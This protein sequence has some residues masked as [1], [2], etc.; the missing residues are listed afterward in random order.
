MPGHHQGF[1]LAR[2][3]PPRGALEAHGVAGHRAHRS[4]LL[5]PWWTEITI[6][7]PGEAAV[8]SG[9]GISTT[10]VVANPDVRTHGRR[11]PGRD[12]YFT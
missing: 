1:D 8:R 3:A 11:I 5:D 2:E 12:A 10:C 9:P 7:K 6:S 4:R